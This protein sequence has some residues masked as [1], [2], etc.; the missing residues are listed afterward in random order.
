MLPPGDAGSAAGGSVFC[1]QDCSAGPASATGVAMAGAN[2]TE[3]LNIGSRSVTSERSVRFIDDLW[4]SVPSARIAA[5]RYCARTRPF[6][7]PIVRNRRGT[8]RYGPITC[9]GAT[10]GGGGTGVRRLGGGGAQD[11]AGGPGLRRPPAGGG[12]R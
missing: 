12:G 3:A 2:R 9:S 5:H 10:G 6:V 8:V 4:R 11:R 7:S 1:E